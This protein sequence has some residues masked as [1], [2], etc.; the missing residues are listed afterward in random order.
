MIWN[1]IL[2][3]AL[4]AADGAGKRAD[5]RRRSERI[6]V[7]GEVRLAEQVA[8]AAV[9]HRKLVV[10]QVLDDARD[11]PLQHRLVH[12]D[13]LDQRQLGRV[14]LREVGLRRR[15]VGDALVDE[16]AQLALELRHQRR[17]FALERAARVEEQLL[18]LADVG[19]VRAVHQ[20]VPDAIEDL[21][22][23]RR[24]AR[25]RHVAAFA[26]NAREFLRRLAPRR[27]A[28]WSARSRQ[29]APAPRHA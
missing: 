29:W 22:E 25:D 5:D 2:R 26:Q 6:R 13:G 24:Q 3:S 4:Q 11:V 27:P 18:L 12:R 20:H 1:L 17:A 21:P 9:E 15:A 8:D 16:L 7:A 10:A 19:L 28:Q 14:D 23:R